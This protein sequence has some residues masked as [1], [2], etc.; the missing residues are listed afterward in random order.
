MIQNTNEG[1]LFD[2]LFKGLSYS[3]YLRD[4][5]DYGYAKTKDEPCVQVRERIDM[6]INDLVELVP[7]AEEYSVAESIE[8]FYENAICVLVAT[9]YIGIYTF[10]CIWYKFYEIIYYH[11]YTFTYLNTWLIFGLSIAIIIKVTQILRI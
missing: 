5:D 11:V 3:K 9:L 4:L 1:K 7:D 2:K 6:V 8:V 10:F